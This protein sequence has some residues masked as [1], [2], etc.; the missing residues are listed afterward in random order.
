MVAG[1]VAFLNGVIGD[2][3]VQADLDELFRVLHPKIVASAQVDAYEA[4]DVETQAAS[5]LDLFELPELVQGL[6]P[7]FARSATKVAD[8]LAGMTEAEPA[9]G[10]S[11]QPMQ[12]VPSAK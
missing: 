10:V 8:M 7:F 12:P 2:D 3:G 9:P 1:L 5:V 6:L 4:G 11:S